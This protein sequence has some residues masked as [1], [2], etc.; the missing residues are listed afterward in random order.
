VLPCD[1]GFD[2]PAQQA[3]PAKEADHGEADP[4]SFREK[5]TKRATAG[6]GAGWVTALGGDAC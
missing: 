6:A 5:V 2:G 4:N 3:D 1:L